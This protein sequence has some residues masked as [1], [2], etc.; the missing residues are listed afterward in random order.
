ME[1]IKRGEET[2]HVFYLT[3]PCTHG[4]PDRLTPLYLVEENAL[5][6]AESGVWQCRDCGSMHYTRKSWAKHVGLVVNIM[7]KCPVLY[8]PKEDEI[9]TASLE[10]D[11]Y[12]D[13]MEPFL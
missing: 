10:D 2:P 4:K 3:I 9:R 11:D 13:D 1:T 5:G 6:G 7:G 8:P 12:G